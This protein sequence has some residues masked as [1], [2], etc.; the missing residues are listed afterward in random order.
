MVLCLAEGFQDLDF[1]IGILGAPGEDHAQL[2][3]SDRCTAAESG[4]DAPVLD[5]LHGKP[6]QILVCFLG[7]FGLGLRLG[8]LGRIEDH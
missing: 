7:A 6:I 5:F 1:Y 3:A 2:F 8:K 4:D